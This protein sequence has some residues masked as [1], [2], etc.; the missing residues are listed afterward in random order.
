MASLVFATFG[1]AL[2]L[3]ALLTFRRQSRVTSCQ[4]HSRL[5]GR[6]AVVLAYTLHDCSPLTSCERGPLDSR[7]PGSP[8]GGLLTPRVGRNFPKKVRFPT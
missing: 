8:A 3:V 6:F 5:L 2:I 4:R 1:A 7:S